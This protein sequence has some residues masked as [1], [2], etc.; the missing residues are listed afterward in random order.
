[1]KKL[2]K[3]AFIT[4]V[5]ERGIIEE[6]ESSQIFLTPQNLCFNLN[7]RTQERKPRSPAK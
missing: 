1:M 5:S 6:L 4:Q 2:S 7:K 3:L